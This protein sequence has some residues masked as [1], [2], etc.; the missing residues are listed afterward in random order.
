MMIMMMT[1]RMMGECNDFFFIKN[2]ILNMKKVLDGG[3]GECR[4][5]EGEKRC[6]V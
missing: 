6:R 1:D 4:V 5:R 2:K 3:M